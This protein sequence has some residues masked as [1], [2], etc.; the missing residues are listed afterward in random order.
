MNE[1]L[2]HSQPS[3]ESSLSTVRCSSFFSS[4]QI[5]LLPLLISPEPL[6]LGFLTHLCF[7]YVFC[8]SLAYPFSIFDV[9]SLCETFSCLVA[10][11][12]SSFIPLPVFFS[13]S[14]VDSLL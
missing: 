11:I 12:V 8:P 14:V 4:T 2:L 3:P 6:L 1:W 5:W 10:S 7:Q 13:A 9:E